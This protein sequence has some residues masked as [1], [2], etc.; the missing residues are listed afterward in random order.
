MPREADSEV[1]VKSADVDMSPEASGF[2]WFMARVGR[3]VVD[4]LAECPM[5]GVL[6]GTNLS[7]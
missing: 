1:V 6:D 4:E 7:S 5:D 2:C 3:A